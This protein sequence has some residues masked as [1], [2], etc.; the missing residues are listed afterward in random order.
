V[1]SLLLRQPRLGLLSAAFVGG[2]GA[3]GL[4]A[5]MALTH[6]TFWLNVVAGNANGFD[7]NQLM[8][9]LGN[10]SV[11]HCVLIAMAVA[12]CLW[13]VRRRHWSPWALYGVA[14]GL[15]TLGVAKWGAGES[16]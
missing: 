12:E 6:G 9:Y 13:M 7:L 2:L 16:Y 11:L 5:L 14:A 3:A 10:F 1:V 15:A 4:A 8:A